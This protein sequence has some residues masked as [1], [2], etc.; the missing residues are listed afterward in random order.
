M[1]VTR[2][3]DLLD[4][5]KENYP[6]A[7]VF[8]AKEDGKW[9]KH[10]LNEYYEKS[11][12]VSY[13]LLNLGLKRGEKVALISSSRPEWNFL[14]MGV[15]QMG[16]IMVPIY[17]T[18]SEDD[19]KY[20]LSHAEVRFIFL[21]GPELLRKIKNILPELPNVEKIYTFKKRDENTNSFDEL[22]EL[23]RENPRA[24]ELKEIKAS[25]LPSDMVTMI[26]TSGTTGFPKGVMLSHE[27]LI[28]NFL[29]VRD[30]PNPE[31]SRAL[32]YLP[33]CHIYERMMNYMYQHR[34]FEIF[35]AESPAKVADNIKETL[36]EMMT[37]VPRLMEKIYDKVYR[38]GEKMTGIKKKIF[39]WALDFAT[40]Y[41]SEKDSFFYNLQ[42][43]IAD[44]FVYSAI[45]ENFGGYLQLI[46]SGG[47]AIQPRLA[48]FFNCLGLLI[49]EGYG[50][51]ETSPVIAV[52][53]REKGGRRVGTVGP[54]L[55]GIEVMISPENNEI[56]C[57]GKNVML[58]YYK[59]PE[60]T[61]EAIDKDGWFHTGD[62]G[63]LEKG[64][65]RI[66]GRCKSLFKTSMG[67]F[68]NPEAIESKFKESPFISDMMVVG[69]NQKFAA[70]LITPDFEFLKEWQIRHGIKCNSQ[71]EMINNKE[72]LQRY[73]KVLSKYNKYFGDTEQVKR[74]KLINGDWT[75]ANGCLTPTLKLKRKKVSELY[76]D[77]IDEL[78]K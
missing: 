28:S 6:T 58:G 18:I 10:Y 48:R 34:G 21:E 74:F 3:F 24:E 9:V 65:L 38:K 43:N 61:A 45:R 8:T 5:R 59:S 42:K 46:V 57:R 29:A 78:F 77:E 15:Q 73:Q 49:F 62:T 35:Y 50:L 66:T 53:R 63:V 40:K 70:A 13:G 17:P 33:L 16:G 69:E 71:E 30:I 76:K 32:S 60:L 41:D 14:D 75:E 4:Y 25:I 2:L 19:Y 72:T 11:E 26:Y 36:P 55:T 64:H 37:T 56:L 51:T 7:P 1:E 54:P 27:N 20:I 31:F 39:Y 67:K 68:V 12:L 52:S 22:L 44:K 23:G 47:A